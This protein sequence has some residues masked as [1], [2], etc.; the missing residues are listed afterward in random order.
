MDKGLSNCKYS[1]PFN[2]GK[3]NEETYSNTGFWYLFAVVAKYGSN[4]L[5]EESRDH[6]ERLGINLLL[7]SLK[8]ITPHTDI[9][10]LVKYVV[11]KSQSELVQNIDELKLKNEI[12]ELEDKNSLQQIE[13]LKASLERSEEKSRKLEL[14]TEITRNILN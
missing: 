8:M 2:Y 13:E 4:R 9:S 7:H 14:L 3:E 10:T 1:L 11:K 5:G 12:R 6:K